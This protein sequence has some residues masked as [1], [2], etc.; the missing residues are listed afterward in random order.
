MAKLR[1]FIAYRRLERPYTRVSKFREK[2]YIR[3]TPHVKIAKFD[4]GNLKKRF[5]Y[6]LSLV[7]KTDL[8][9]RDNALDSARQTCN[10]LLEKTLTTTGYNLK[11]RIYPHHILRENP[12]ASGAG[13]D[14]MSTGMAHS[15][16]KPIGLAARVRKGQEIITVGVSKEGIETA[17]KALNKA[18]KKLPNAYTITLTETE[19]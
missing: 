9:I 16:G 2:A 3:I 13:A 5:D 11:I 10:R 18:R 8:Q 17:T 1:K 4:M 14:R 12:L 15:F 19:K 7:S 6:Y